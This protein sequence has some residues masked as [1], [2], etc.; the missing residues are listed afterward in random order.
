VK[1]F[2]LASLFSPLFALIVLLALPRR[3]QAPTPTI[4]QPVVP[5][6]VRMVGDDDAKRKDA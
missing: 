4:P 3:D 6:R 5:R 1:W 2:L